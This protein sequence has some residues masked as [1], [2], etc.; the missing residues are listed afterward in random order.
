MHRGEAEDEDMKSM[1]EAELIEIER[2]VS[3]IVA[4]LDADHKL[5]E[6]SEVWEDAAAL[7]YEIRSDIDA[8]CRR[9]RSRP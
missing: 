3:R 8:L 7:A 9:V 5:S 6:L 4:L 2:R 1:T